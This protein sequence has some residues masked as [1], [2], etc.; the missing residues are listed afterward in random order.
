MQEI[1]NSIIT[2][3]GENF[4]T[5]A[6]INYITNLGGSILNIILGAVVSIYLIKDREFFKRLWRKTLH[7]LLPQKANAIVTETLNDIN[8]VLSQF[9]RGQLL[10]ALIIAILSSI[11]LTVIGVDFGVFIGC[12]AG[13]AN[14]I[15]YFGPIIGMIPAAVVALLTEGIGQ[16]VLAVIVLFIIQQI[17]GN[18]IYPKIVG[19]SIGLHPVFVLIAV[20]VG[21]YYLGIVGM[22]I[23]VPIAA[24]IKTFIMKKLDAAEVT[25]D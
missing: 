13:I 1:L 11:A 3:F 5:S 14:V 4:S 23:A 21:G 7:I 8:V 22:L 9:L 12:F 19:S 17:D 2:W 15:P 6:V 25:D 24:I 18:L 16:A 10:D 20:T